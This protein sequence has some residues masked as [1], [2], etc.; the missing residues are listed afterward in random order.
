[1][2]NQMFTSR[3]GEKRERVHPAE[4]AADHPLV[5]S[6]TEE[7]KTLR[8]LSTGRF[9]SRRKRYWETECCCDTWQNHDIYALAVQRSNYRFDCG[10]IRYMSNI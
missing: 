7:C 1:M 2:Y 10:V 6:L 4:V 9:C 3:F 5:P 8:A